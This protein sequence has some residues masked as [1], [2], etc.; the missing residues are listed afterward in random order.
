MFQLGLKIGLG[1]GFR[2]RIGNLIGVAAG[3][4]ILMTSYACASAVESHM[5]NSHTIHEIETLG[6]FTFWII[7]HDHPEVRAYP[8]ANPKSEVVF[9]V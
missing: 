3:A 5:C 9:F 8:V 2:V 6:D 7:Q 1:L 4:H